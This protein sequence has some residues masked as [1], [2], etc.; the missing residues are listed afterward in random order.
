M[1]HLLFSLLL[2]FAAV[3]PTTITV[4]PATAPSATS[5]STDDDDASLWTYHLAYH[6]AQ[7]AVCAGSVTY[8]RFNGNLLVY[9]DADGS[10]R[11]YTRRNGLSD[12]GISAMG[13]SETQ[14]CLVLLYTS[15]NIDLLFDDGTVVNIPQVKNF[16]EYDVNINR[17]NVANDWATLSTTEG[18]IVVDLKRREVKAYY[19]FLQSV[20]DAV[21]M[22][23]QRVIA[24]LDHTVVSGLMTDNL[25]S[26]SEWK[27][28]ANLLVSQFLAF[29]DGCY[30]LAPYVKGQA[31][32]CGGLYYA[33]TDVSEGWDMQ[34]VSPTYL[35]QGNTTGRM[36]QFVGSWGIHFAS[37]DHP[38]QLSTVG[39]GRYI[40]DA[41]R[42]TDGQ[43]WVLENAKFSRYAYDPSA[44]TLTLSD[45]T[46]MAGFGP[47]RDLAYRMRYEGDRLLIAGGLHTNVC[48]PT[49]M[50][51][52]DG[53]WT[54]FQT[55]GSNVV[56]NKD[57]WLTDYT[58]I[59]QDPADPTHHFIGFFGGIAE[60][61]DFQFVKH[62]GTANS[63]LEHEQHSGLDRPKYAIVDYLEYD[64]DGNLWVLNSQ[65][66]KGVKVLKT[67]GTWASIPVDGLNEYSLQLGKMLFDNYG[68]VWI[69][70]SIQSSVSSGLACLDY[71]GTIDDTD[72]DQSQLRF[73]ATNEDGTTCNLQDVNDMCFDHNDQL[74][75]AGG[76]GVFVVQ[77]PEKWFASDFSIYQPKVPRNDGTNYADYLLSDIA[78]SAIAVDGG[79]RKWLGTIG[80]GIYLVNSDGSEVI[81]HFTTDNSPLLS[82]NIYSLVIHPTTGELMIGTD[83]GLC[84]YRTGVTQPEQ[85]LEKNNV[86]VYPNPVRPEYHGRITISGL[87]DG[88]EVKI[89]STG[90]QLVA[91]GNST[92]GSFLWDG[93]HAGGHRVAPGV[94][95]VMVATADGKTSVAARIVVI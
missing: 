79:N 50:A 76:H 9:D 81:S 20:R 16:S 88:A 6:E 58:T 61:K 40:T 91:R 46:A 60:Y 12:K 54:F 72:D 90:G 31:D 37:A 74:W 59:V 18:V 17:L 78:V 8:A 22:G 44:A 75:I 70:S 30:L 69:A 77:Q 24:A 28:T 53:K 86:K 95:H 43:V 4:L 5:V 39:M 80:S 15:K 1:R 47:L 63:G 49:A 85:Q 38:T 14:H 57:V 51:Y 65:T 71:D 26:L 11:E 48:Q 83:A 10:V 94:Y 3:R 45:T 7:Q 82:D 84:S 93:C 32:G 36:A 21:V 27:Q 42:S 55:E 62:Y 52:E 34:Q 35:D 25:Y 33:R 2:L 68:R 41:T 23:S 92:G 56:T 73:S 13:Y 87:T 67:D 64:A 66:K 89:L 19:R 29:A